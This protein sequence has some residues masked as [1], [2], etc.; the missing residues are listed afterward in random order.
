MAEDNKE[1]IAPEAERPT[2]DEWMDETLRKRDGNDLVRAN[3]LYY[4]LRANMSVFREALIR[5]YKDKSGHLKEDSPDFAEAQ[6]EWLYLNEK[7]LVLRSFALRFYDLPMPSI[8]DIMP[9]RLYF[10]TLMHEED[11][12]RLMTPPEGHIL[13][14]KKPE[15]AKDY[16]PKKLANKHTDNLFPGENS[17]DSDD[18]SE[19]EDKD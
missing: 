5:L 11:Y 7:M 2:F 12:R 3:T 10:G 6:M 16:D 14:V 4:G 9:D 13:E 19:A 8:H 15:C 17:S 18:D 1:N